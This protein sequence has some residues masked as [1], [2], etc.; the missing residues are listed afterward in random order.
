MK[1]FFNMKKLFY[2]TQ[3]C[4]QF[5]LIT[6]ELMQKCASSQFKDAHIFISE[7]SHFQKL[8]KSRYTETVAQ[9]LTHVIGDPTVNI[10]LF[11]LSR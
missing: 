8:L 6:N 3:H 1:S 11:Q 7:M 2:N 10:N 5:L 9:F 4:K